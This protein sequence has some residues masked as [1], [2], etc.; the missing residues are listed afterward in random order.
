MSIVKLN[1]ALKKINNKSKSIRTI[2]TKAE[3]LV[4]EDTI[5]LKTNGVPFIVSI[6]Y[7]GVG[8]FSSLMPLY[9]KV[10][11]GNGKIIINNLFKK[12]IQERL[13]F[14]SGNPEIISC[15]ITSQDGSKLSATINDIK[16]INLLNNSETNLEDD[17]LILFEEPKQQKAKL[18]S[19]GLAP[20]KISRSSFNSQGKVQK[21]GKKEIEE[22][23]NIITEI[24]PS[25]TSVSKERTAKQPVRVSQSAQRQLSRTRLRVPT[26]K[27]ALDEKKK[28]GGKY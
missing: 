6:A 8:L 17:T 23:A 19:S 14:Y 13:L 22:I 25:I 9:I 15:V 1:K 16:K 11:E 10:I 21:V 7:S 27:I 12:N 28:L 5:R 2:C 20:K 24:S 26:V 3:L 18:S 4:S